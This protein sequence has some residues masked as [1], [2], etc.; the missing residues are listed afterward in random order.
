MC[1]SIGRTT[2]RRRQ[3]EV[4]A[5]ILLA[6]ETG[7]EMLIARGDFPEGKSRDREHPW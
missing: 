3:E 5:W 1:Q 4:W 2:S 6:L 7:R